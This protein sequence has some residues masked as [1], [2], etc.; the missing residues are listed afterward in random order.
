MNEIYEIREKSR[1]LHPF[2]VEDLGLEQ[3]VESVK[4]RFQKNYNVII[5]THYQLKLTL[6]SKTLSIAAFRIIKELIYNAIKHSGS[7]VISISLLCVDRY[8]V[9]KVTDKGKGFEI[10]KAIDHTRSDH[11][12]LITIQRRVDQLNGL[13]EIQS[14]VGKGTSIKITLP[15][16]WNEERDH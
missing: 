5:D 12:G 2:I 1:E 7:R 3:S 9:M 14:V 4:K 16:D 13:V 8:L 11:I 6:I 10:T 15:L